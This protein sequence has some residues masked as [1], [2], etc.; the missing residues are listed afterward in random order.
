M[1]D[2]ELIGAPAFLVAV[3]GGTFT[4]TSINRRLS[5]LIGVDSRDFIGQTPETLLSTDHAARTVA[6]YRR[7][8]GEHRSVEFES[9]YDPP[10]GCPL[11]ADHHIPRLRRRGGQVAQ[12][13]GVA[14]DVTAA[15]PRSAAAARSMIAS[16]SP[17]ISWKAA[18]GI[19]PSETTASRRRRS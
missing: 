16:R 17:W 12:L 15:R 7:C 2:V 14:S 6:Q 1:I 9:F 13:I 8:I 11:V 18:F 10:R 3:A 19:I 4:Y 5:E